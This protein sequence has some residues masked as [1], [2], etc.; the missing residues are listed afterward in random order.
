MK[1]AFTTI[2]VIVVIVIIGILSAIA[3]TNQQNNNMA[4]AAHQVLNHIR[5]TQHLAISQHKF[6]PKDIVFMKT[7]GNSAANKGKYY[8]GWWQIRFQVISPTNAANG[9]IGYSVYSDFDRQGGI[10]VKN[11]L[12]PAINPSD[13]RW[14]RLFDDCSGCS[15]DVFLD[16]KYQITN[17]TFSDNCQ[18]VGFRASSL[19]STVG[20]IVFDEKGI[21]YFGIANNNQNNPY[22]YKLTT[23]CNITLTGSGGGTA[24]IAV[25][26]ETGYAKI[27]NITEN[28]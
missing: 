18:D 20:T 6:D 1:K 24:T 16:R 5:Y 22:Q 2:E 14:L 9:L 27:T 4:L 11:V 10:D 15:D 23:T 12:N 21:P 13:G 26:P 25:E 7:P 8:R 3:L 17:I 19:Q 28:N